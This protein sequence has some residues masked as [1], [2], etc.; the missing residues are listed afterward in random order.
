M[1]AIQAKLVVGTL[2]AKSVVETSSDPW[3]RFYAADDWGGVVAEA[4]A[5]GGV[6]A[7]IARQLCYVIGCF[8]L[9][10]SFLRSLHVGRLLFLLIKWRLGR[11][12]T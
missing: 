3:V 1:V 5:I 7:T 10:I 9:P 12:W 6:A 8:C 4:S 11:W 2:Q